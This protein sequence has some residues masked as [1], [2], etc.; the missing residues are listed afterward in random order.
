M[1]DQNKR[2]TVLDPR[3]LS[4]QLHYR[5][6][7]NPPPA[8][9]DTTIGNTCPGLEFDFRAAWRTLL[10]GVTL[11][12]H[13]NLVIATEPA[14]AAM[15]GRRLLRVD[16]K[17]VITKVIGPSTDLTTT[18]LLTSEDYPAGVITM[19]WSNGF[20]EVLRKAGQSVSCEFTA[21][22]QEERISYEQAV[23]DRNVQ[24]IQ[25]QVRPFFTANTAAIEPATVPAGVMTQGLCSPWQNDYRECVCYYWASSRPDFVNAEVTPTGE[26]RGDNW[27][28]KE[29]TG[30]YVID[31]YE[32][33]RMITYDDLF[34][35]WEEALK[36]QLAGHD[37]PDEIP[38]PFPKDK[39]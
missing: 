22:P 32:D 5:P 7:G 37:A 30:T 29:R 11:L 35:N 6:A 21:R 1:S 31:N 23:K 33:S 27:M 10:V 3:N 13:D 15:K 34:Q 8:T 24:A 20:A 38:L 14:F 25:F 18:E 26:V 28:Q 36:F 19:E 16:G 9:L 2:P 4:A 39:A 12:E 17:P